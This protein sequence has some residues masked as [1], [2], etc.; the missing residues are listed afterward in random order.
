MP[1]RP[2]QLD[3]AHR[4]LRGAP[5]IVIVLAIAKAISVYALGRIED[6]PVRFTLRRVEHLLVGLVSLLITV[7]IVFVN[8]YAALTALGIGSIIIG[9]AVQTPIKILFV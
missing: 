8:W 4:I 1:L 2:S 7:S 9:L 6:A 3:L 5:V